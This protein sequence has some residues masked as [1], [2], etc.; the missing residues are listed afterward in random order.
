M[1]A[2]L[3][4]QVKLTGAIPR[5]YAVKVIDEVVGG[6]KTTR[7]LNHPLLTIRSSDGEVTVIYDTLQKFLVSLCQQH[8]T[9][10]ITP[11]KRA[12]ISFSNGHFMLK[13]VGE[14]PDVPFVNIS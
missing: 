13:H 10:T 14:W 2:E 11:K 5:P 3:L 12:H 9:L 4:Q 1:A 6:T 7:K 8:I